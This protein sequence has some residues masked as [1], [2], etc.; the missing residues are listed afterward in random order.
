VRSRLD[1]AF[2]LVGRCVADG[3]FGEWY[4]R[5]ALDRIGVLAEV[6]FLFEAGEEQAA[7][8]LLRAA[9]P[10]YRPEEDE[11]LPGRVD[12]LLKTMG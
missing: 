10:D 11:S 5:D 4:F 3:Q 6:A 1:G 12:D 8:H 7:S 2:D 9:T